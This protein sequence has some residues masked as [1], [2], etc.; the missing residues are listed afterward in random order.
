MRP[1]SRLSARISVFH[2]GI[3][4][5]LIEGSGGAGFPGQGPALT[6]NRLLLGYSDES[7][8]VPPMPQPEVLGHNGTF[9]AFRKLHERVAAFR[10]FLH[11]HSYTAEEE[12]L[13]AAKMWGAGGAALR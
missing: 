4:Q 8:Q 5:P 11:E 6:T 7:A 10:Q 9:L 2:D 13:L 3:G 12:E 1:S